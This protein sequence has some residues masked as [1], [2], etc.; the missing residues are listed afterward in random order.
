M[1]NMLHIL[2]KLPVIQNKASQWT[3]D[4]IHVGILQTSR[5]AKDFCN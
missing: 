3:I 5:Q 4:F 1:L 2:K